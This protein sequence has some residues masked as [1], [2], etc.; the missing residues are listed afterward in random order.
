MLAPLSQPVPEVGELKH[1]CDLN[2]GIPFSSKGMGRPRAGL[3]L[4]FPELGP[5]PGL[6]THSRDLA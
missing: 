1:C 5:L 3:N 2:L 6:L 4:E